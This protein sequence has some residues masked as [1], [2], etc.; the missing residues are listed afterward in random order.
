MRLRSTST[1]IPAGSTKAVI[2][3]A[4]PSGELLVSGGYSGPTTG[5][6]ARAT[7]RYELDF[8]KWNTIFVNLTN[9]SQAATVTGGCVNFS[10]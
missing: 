1:T 10:Q 7:M 2:T 5:L 8:A 6:Y 3:S 4:C 9:S